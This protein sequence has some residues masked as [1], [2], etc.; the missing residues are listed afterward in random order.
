MSIGHNKPPTLREELEIETLDLQAR[1]RELIGAA[2]RCEVTDDDTAAKATLLARMMKD[3]AKLIDTARVARKE[4]FLVAGRDVDAHFKTLVGPVETASS[5][6]ISLIDAYRRKK[7]AEAAAERRRIEEEARKRQ[8]EADRLS[9]AAVTVE[10]EIRATQAQNAAQ[11]VLRKAEETVAAPIRDGYGGAA[12]RRTVWTHQ[13]DN[14]KTALAHAVKVDQ[15][16]I[17]AAVEDVIKRQI[18]A[19]V[20]V[21]P[22]TTIR[23]DS[24]TVIR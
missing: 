16:T 9:A 13:I 12:G 4:P 23:E 21:F 14:F 11:D 19:G 24:T 8:E 17:L 6:V 2:E 1:N 5:K 18:R 22:G 20:R 3:Q 15:A 7:E 10:D